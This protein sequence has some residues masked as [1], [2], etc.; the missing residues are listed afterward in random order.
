MVAVCSEGPYSMFMMLLFSVSIFVDIH[1]RAKSRKELIETKPFL[2]ESPIRFKV[3]Q[4]VRHALRIPFSRT[5]A[6]KAPA[7]RLFAASS[8]C[9]A[10]PGPSKPSAPSDTETHFGFKSV[11]ES[12]KESLVGGVFSSVASSYDVM[13]SRAFD[14][15][16]RSVL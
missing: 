11:P 10:V 3:M 2:D 8:R 14:E 1:C 12:L 13:V 16:R 6:Q 4:V 5:A 15:E 7:S 9:H